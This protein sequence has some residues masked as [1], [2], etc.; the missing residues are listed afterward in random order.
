[1]TDWIDDEAGLYP[2]VISDELV[3]AYSS[4]KKSE[5]LAKNS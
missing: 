5:D 2:L 1:M 4:L 3:E